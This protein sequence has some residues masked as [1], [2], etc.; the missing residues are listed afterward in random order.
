M[1]A[2]R[3]AQLRRGLACS[4]K[5]PPR[6]QNLGRLACLPQQRIDAADLP[7]AHATQVFGTLLVWVGS[8]VGQTIAFVIGRYLL[9]ELVVQYLTRQ[10]PKWTAIDKALETGALGVVAVRRSAV[11]LWAARPPAAVWLP[12]AAVLPWT[13]RH[14][15]PQSCLLRL[16][17]VCSWVCWHA[18][19][20]TPN[21]I[22]HL[23]SRG[24]EAGHAAAAEPHRALERAQLRAVRHRRPASRLLHRLLAG[25]EPS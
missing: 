21:P 16:F 11:L 3:R 17:C 14:H 13:A 6:V 9:R 18:I 7:L 19:L 22:H 24:L 2:A 1:V 12:A 5:L 15:G 10:F 20:K 4:C 8:S 23:R 25:G